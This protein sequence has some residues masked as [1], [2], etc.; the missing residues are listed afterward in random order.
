VFER[1]TREFSSHLFNVS[2]IN[3]WLTRI[4][5]DNYGCITL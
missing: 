1:E 2:N 5:L 4:T 3:V